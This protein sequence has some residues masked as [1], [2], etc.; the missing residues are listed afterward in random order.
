MPQLYLWAHI[1]TCSTSRPPFP[2]RRFLKRTRGT[3]CIPFQFFVRKLIVRNWASVFPSS[4][5]AH[6]HYY[7]DYSQVGFWGKPLLIK[8]I[9]RITNDHQSKLA[10]HDVFPFVLL[11]TLHNFPVQWILIC[12]FIHNCSAIYVIN[13]FHFL[14][15]YFLPFGRLFSTKCF[16]RWRFVIVP[17]TNIWIEL[18]P[19]RCLALSVLI[20]T[21]W[22]WDAIWCYTLRSNIQIIWLRC[23]STLN[24]H[25]FHC[26]LW[27]IFLPQSS[28][29]VFMWWQSRFSTTWFEVSALIHRSESLLNLCIPRVLK[30]NGKP[31]FTEVSILSNYQF[32]IMRKIALVYLISVPEIY[33]HFHAIVEIFWFLTVVSMRECCA[34]KHG[35][36]CHAYGLFNLLLIGYYYFL[37]VF[38]VPFSK[39]ADCII[40]TSPSNGDS[41][42]PAS[43]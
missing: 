34:S 11:A 23:F 21:C 36:M 1:I 12:M 40:V 24:I 28:V 31:L 30:R 4:L 8:V 22:L 6:A 39:Y 42:P 19:S 2:L 38:A 17:L 5:F 43:S 29:G 37:T 33:A 41:C 26:R 13:S 9:F 14:N 25:R 15:Y 32:L 16:S 3:R 20:S 35:Y 27:H 18:K 7:H 10:L